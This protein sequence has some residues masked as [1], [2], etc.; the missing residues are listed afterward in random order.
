MDFIFRCRTEHREHRVGGKRKR[1]MGELSGNKELGMKG[2]ESE[3]EVWG[4]SW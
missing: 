1:K 3:K 2:W 4:G